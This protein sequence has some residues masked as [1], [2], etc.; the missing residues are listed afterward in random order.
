MTR[1]PHGPTCLACTDPAEAARQI[2]AARA[3]LDAEAA[4]ARDHRAK[5]EAA[6]NQVEKLHHLGAANAIAS[7][8]RM[9]RAHLNRVEAAHPK[10]REE[11]PR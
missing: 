11:A 2:A 7:G 6:Q 5:G 1:Y 10:L 8:I 9:E 4:R 3:R